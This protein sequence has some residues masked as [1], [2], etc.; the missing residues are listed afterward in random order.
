MRVLASVLPGTGH[1]LPLVPT[2][3]ALRDAGHTVLVASAEPLRVE[4]EAAELDFAPVGPPWHE[5]DAD[6][7]LPGFQA[8]GSA[9]QLGMFA[10]LAPTV[11]PDLLTLAGNVRPDLLV[12]EPYEFAAWLAAGRCQLPIVV[13]AIGVVSGSP[14]LFA[15]LAGEPLAAARAAAGLP[16]DPDLRSLYGR[17]L[18]TFYP[19]SLRFLQL[20]PPDVSHRLVRLPPPG[21]AQLPFERI[22]PGRP[23]V[24]ITLGTV[25]NTTVDLLRTLV[26][27][28]AAL[29]VDVLITTGQA[30]D[31]A[32]LGRQPD[33]VH[34]ARFVPQHQVLDAA[35]AVVCHAG[36]GT[37]YGALSVGVPLVVA[38][39]AA[40]QP[41]CAMGCVLAGTAVSL[42][43]VPPP[44]DFMA[45]VTDPA[46]VT[47]AQ[48]SEATTR[49]LENPTY[50]EAA[51]RIAAEIAATPLPASVV[52]WLA[53]LA[54]AV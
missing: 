20:P 40:D 7:L 15:A 53:S 23:L 50:R 21:P 48:V 10:E 45:F 44:E 33:H 17:G 41:I 42:A 28:V 3:H 36:V 24:Y 13:H 12:R 25:F 11:L 18:I 32:V 27:G 30:V 14:L 1:L 47:A 16:A 54:G 46:A 8:A 26:A 51:R 22:R 38:P 29:D 35:A 34:A 19:S 4:V 6:A 31:P 5:S 49:V 52:P 43:P 39:L 2:L 9:G 37:V